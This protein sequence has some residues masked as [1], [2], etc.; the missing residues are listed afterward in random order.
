MC[1]DYCC[2]SAPAL[3]SRCLCRCRFCCQFYSAYLLPRTCHSK[4]TIAILPYN[5]Y[6][7][8]FVACKTRLSISQDVRAR[9]LLVFKGFTSTEFDSGMLQE[10][11][12][13]V[14][15]SLYGG[16]PCGLKVYR[17]RRKRP[18]QA[19]LFLMNPQRAVLGACPV[20]GVWRLV[21]SRQPV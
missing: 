12:C 5:K 17:D 3:T 4:F 13:T 19:I 2:H 10:S 7:I 14:T 1:H 16:K 11:Q 6:S 18:K 9:K 20:S 8:L 15:E 21:W